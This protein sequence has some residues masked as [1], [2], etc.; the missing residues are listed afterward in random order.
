MA[1]AYCTESHPHTRGD[2]FV[3]RNGTVSLCP[4]LTALRGTAAKH[5]I[6]QTTTPPRRA[7][8]LYLTT[9]AQTGLT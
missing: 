8:A 4:L 7:T 5:T 3:V 9:G 1:L 6:G 2:W